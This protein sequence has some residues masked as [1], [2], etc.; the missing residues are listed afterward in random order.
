MADV[1]KEN[2]YTQIANK[3]L[4]AIV[5]T[6]MSNYEHRVFWLIV[7]KTYGYNKKSD[8]I[9]QKQIVEATGILKQHISRT[10]KRLK[11]KNMIVVI[12]KKMAIQKDY[13]LW[14]LPK[15]VTKEVT[16]TGYKELPESVTEVTQ[17]GVKS[18]LNGGIQKKKET[19]QKKFKESPAYLLSEYLF[20]KIKENNPEHKKPNL[21]SWA[22]HIDKLIRLDKRTPE[23]IKEV[24]N[25][26][27]SDNFWYKNIL[28]TEKLRKQYDQLVM[29][30]KGKKQEFNIDDISL[31]D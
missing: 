12:D 17:T 14:E 26:C 5:R 19:I 11:E 2:G 28:S 27:Q 15:Q 16:Q 18:N 20:K 31:E 6:Y 30:M 4:E 22:S 7:R 9:S 24:I 21:T 13:D 3:L 8:W 29:N 23:K 10:V 1:Q 25:W